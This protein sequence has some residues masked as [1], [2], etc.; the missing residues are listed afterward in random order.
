MKRINFTIEEKQIEQ[1]KDYFKSSGIRMSETVR[2]A[3]D[4]YFIQEKLK[5]EKQDE[6]VTK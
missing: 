5:K 6:S 4:L 3:I 1:L 2:R